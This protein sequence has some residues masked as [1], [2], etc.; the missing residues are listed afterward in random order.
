MFTNW[1][2]AKIES[3][4]F[5]QF[6]CSRLELSPTPGGVH[7]NMFVYNHHD[8]EHL[9]C[10][11][12]CFSC[13][14]SCQILSSWE[15]GKTLILIVLSGWL[16]SRLTRMLFSRYADEQSLN[17]YMNEYN[18][19]RWLDRPTRNPRMGMPSCMNQD[20]WTPST[21]LTNQSLK[22]WCVISKE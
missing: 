20:L 12:I 3:S 19:E 6:N 16:T 2:E 4:C 10:P 13:W 11:L 1:R 21:H 9:D 8:G 14:P 17:H 22:R 5:H 7:D 18:R 15:I